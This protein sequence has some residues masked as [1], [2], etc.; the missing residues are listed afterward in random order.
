MKHIESIVNEDLANCWTCSNCISKG[1][2]SKLEELKKETANKTT[3]NNSGN[4]SMN[5]TFNT[6][7]DSNMNSEDDLNEQFSDLEDY[8]VKKNFSEQS[9]RVL[10]LSSLTNREKRIILEEFCEILV[11]EEPIEPK[12]SLKSK[13]KVKTELMVPEEEIGISD[14]F[15]Q[16][17]EQQNSNLNSSAESP[18][19]LEEEPTT[20]SQILQVM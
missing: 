16:E 18:M 12:Y 10:T 19:L 14:L 3:T 17:G 11:D 15:K 6:N 9:N 20:I 1:F 13:K 2:H 4:N 8:D 7:T 5:N